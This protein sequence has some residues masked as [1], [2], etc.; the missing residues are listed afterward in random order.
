MHR[1]GTNYLYTLLCLHPHVAR[2][3][4][5]FEDFLTSRADLLHA[6][7]HETFKK[8]NPEWHAVERVGAPETLTARFGDALLDFLRLQFAPPNAALPPHKKDARFFVTKT[9]SVQ[10]LAYFFELFPRAPLLLLVRDG[11]AVI[12]SGMRSF[13]WDFETAARQWAAAARTAQQFIEN[14]AASDRRFL[15]VH[16]ERVF[17]QPAAEVKR[18]LAF[19]ALDPNLYDWARAQELPVSGSSEVRAAN[20][21]KLHWEPRA[22]A[23]DFAPT[24]RWEHWTR[25]Q[26]E[27]FNWLAG[28]MLAYFGYAPRVESTQRRYWMWRNR[29]LDWRGKLRL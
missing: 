28:D 8:W 7:A 16:Y 21:A 27:R 25:A 23:A 19:L 20:S 2:G 11:R 22:R 4:V 9:P 1:T 18:I 13:Q 10:N 26:H 15:L 6:Y 14:S 29:W 3:P 24:R 17:E 5:I 12:E